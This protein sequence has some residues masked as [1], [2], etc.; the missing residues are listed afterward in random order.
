MTQNKGSACRTI[1]IEEVKMSNSAT[2][3]MSGK[4]QV[5]IPEEIRI[6]LNL[7]AGSQFM[8]MGQ[9]DVVILKNIPS[10]SQIEFDD[11]RK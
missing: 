7:K 9:N 6:K 2:I 8:V 1:I 4:G 11:S 3:R 10:H 5:V